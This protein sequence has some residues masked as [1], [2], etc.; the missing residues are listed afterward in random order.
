MFFQ[1]V[2]VENI[3]MRKSRPT[4]K[5]TSGE[6]FSLKRDAEF[7][8]WTVYKKYPYKNPQRHSCCL[9]I[10]HVSSS[11]RFFI[12]FIDWCFIFSSSCRGSWHRQEFCIWQYLSN[13]FRETGWHFSWHTVNSC[14][15][16]IE[17]YIR[18]FLKYFYSLYIKW[19]KIE[20]LYKKIL[21]YSPIHAFFL[22][23]FF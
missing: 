9:R 11:A 7:L 12:L 1:A 22:I 20:T 3:E 8:G 18:D 21:K 5:L 16:I 23:I 19:I 14:A 2:Y 4:L 13:T 15:E 10:S 6:Y 17:R